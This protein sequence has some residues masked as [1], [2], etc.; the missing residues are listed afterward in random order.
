MKVLFQIKSAI[1]LLAFVFSINPAFAQQASTITAADYARAEKF[2]GYN[3]A[4][5]VSGAVSATWASGDRFWYRKGSEFVLVNAADGARQ[6]FPD[7]ARLNAAIADTPE[8]VI[9]NGVPNSVL[10]PDGKRAAYI[11]DYNLWVRDLVTR[12]DTQLTKDGVKDYGYATDNA[13]GTQSDRAILAWS[14]D[15][16]KI[17]TFQQDQR[18]TSDMYLVET[19]VGKPKL[20]AWKYPLPGDTDVTI[21]RKSGSAG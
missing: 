13:G 12:K 15:S 19:T 1:F 10:S 3:T 16:K 8:I 7:Q 9:Q 18:K 4:P 5:L 20:K 14:P 11:K 2:M 17:A 6:T 21:D